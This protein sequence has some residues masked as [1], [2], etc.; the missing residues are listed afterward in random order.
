MAHHTEKAKMLAGELSHP[1]GPEIVAD[2]MRADR[3]LR[4]YHARQQGI[5]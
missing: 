4:A 1:T 5:S 2:A 3:L